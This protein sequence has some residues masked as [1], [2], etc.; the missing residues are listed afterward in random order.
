MKLK[1][2]EKN[3]LSRR[4]F[5]KCTG[6]IVFA[7]GSGGYL[8]SGCE[9]KEDGSAMAISDGYLVVDVEKCQGCI[10]CMLACSLVHEGA[11]SLSYS[12]IQILQDSFGKFPDDLTIEQCRQCE[13]PACVDVCAEGA[14]TA[15][16]E[17]GYVRM[18]DKEKCTG[19]GSCFKACPHTPAR[20]TVMEDETFSRE[21]KSLKCDLCANA[22]HH[23][24]EKGGGPDGKQACVEV[25]PVGAIAF[26]KK[27]PAQ[28]GKS[29]Y[30]VNLR[31]K[32]WVRLGYR[33][34]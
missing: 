31:D 20:L 24:D 32:N 18:V 29:G 19:C 25:C 23:W 7:V 26:R 4:T 17:F 14:L 16:A 8:L 33:D 1:V 2:S 13:A 27:L 5:L 9:V 28:K 22:P 12:R 30:K 6:T 11:E 15:N 21:L 10:S 34:S 3:G